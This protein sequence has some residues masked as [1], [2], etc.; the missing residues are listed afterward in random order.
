MTQPAP[1]KSYQPTQSPTATARIPVF[2]K[3]EDELIAK[4][5]IYQGIIPGDLNQM[6]LEQALTDQGLFFRTEIAYSLR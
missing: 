5:L 4:C 2:A 1:L 3:K 6:Q